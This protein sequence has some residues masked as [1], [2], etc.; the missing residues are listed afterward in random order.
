MK[1][2]REFIINIIR[3]KIYGS[4]TNP[5]ILF[6]NRVVFNEISQQLFCIFVIFESDYS[7]GDFKNI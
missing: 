4:F 2:L 6:N 7:N 3:T 1:F 5:D